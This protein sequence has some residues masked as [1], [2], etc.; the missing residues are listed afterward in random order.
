[1]TGMVEVLKGGV[2]YTGVVEENGRLV[3]SAGRDLTD[4]KLLGVFI[5]SR[6]KD[7]GYYRYYR[8]GRN[9]YQFISGTN[10]YLWF[11][12]ASV[13]DAFKRVWLT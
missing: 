6:Y 13:E 12:D 1:M 9:I 7:D 5:G 2:I 8:N 3:D 4:G 11:C 10:D